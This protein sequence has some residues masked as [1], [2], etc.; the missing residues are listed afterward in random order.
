MDFW[1]NLMP[2][3]GK[4]SFDDEKLGITKP[5]KKDGPDPEKEDK[6]MLIRNRVSRIYTFKKFFDYPISLKLQ[7]FTNMGVIRTVKAGFSYL[8]TKIIK[9]K[10]DSLENFY[11]NRF[12]KSLYSMFFEKYTEKLW[13]RHPKEIDASWGAQ[14]VK[15]V[16]ISAVIKDAFSKIFGKKNNKNIETSLIEQFWYPKFG[17]GQLWEILAEEIENRGGTIKKGYCVKKVNIKNKK[18]VSVECEVNGKKEIIEGDIF[19]SSMPVKDLVL[20]IQGEQVQNEILN[21]AEGLP[22]IDFQTVGVLVKKMKLKNK[23]KIKTLGNI[24]PDCWVYVQEPEVKMLRFQ[25]FNNWSPYLVKDP[26]NSVWIGLEYTCSEGDSYWNMTDEEFTK[27]A[28]NELVSMEIIDK[29][30]VIDSHREKVKKLI[31]HILILIKIWIK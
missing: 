12:G 9:R 1:E 31:Q 30:D 3:Q 13:G 16:S 20:G 22:Y 7:T 5:L 10:E 27:F 11:I 15:G 6:V 19:I 14:R 24:V 21:I 29:E 23:T 2:I 8:K 26:E 25:I 28:I 18:I 17:P 4:N